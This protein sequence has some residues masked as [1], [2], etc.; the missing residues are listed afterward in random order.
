MSI[1]YATVKK[2]HDE[3]VDLKKNYQFRD[4]NETASC[5]GV[6]VSQCYIL[7]TLHRYGPLTMQ[8]LADK[9]RL[10]ISTVTRVVAPLVRQKYVSRNESSEDQ[11]V[12]I[13]ELTKSGHELYLNSWKSTFESEKNILAGFSQEH[14]EMLVE[15]LQKLNKAFVTQRKD[16]NQ[17]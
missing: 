1:D 4:R 10:S 3:L 16:C 13:M 17:K 15:F 5:C 9:M 11:R 14:R 7:E 6:S 8:Q 2:F 12:R